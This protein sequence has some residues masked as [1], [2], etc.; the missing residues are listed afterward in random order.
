MSYKCLNEVV[1]EAEVNFNNE[2]S[3]NSWNYDLNYLVSTTYVVVHCSENIKFDLMIQYQDGNTTILARDVV[4]GKE[5]SFNGTEEMKKNIFVKNLEP[6]FTQVP[7]NSEL[8]YPIR[9]TTLIQ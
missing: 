4:D 7:L 2:T 6:V 5:V 1:L 9:I 3:R 8:I